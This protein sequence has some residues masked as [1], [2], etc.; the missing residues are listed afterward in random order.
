LQ[1]LFIGKKG[2]FMNW[3]PV[4]SSNI[5]AISYNPGTKVLSVRFLKSGV[6]HYND[7]P[8][9]LIDE[10]MEAESV[11][12]YFSQWIKGVFDFVK[13]EPKIEGEGSL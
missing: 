1:E 12:K 10:M 5:E 13:E 3:I 6:Y 7:V 4:E 2:G 8:E 9:H 11:G